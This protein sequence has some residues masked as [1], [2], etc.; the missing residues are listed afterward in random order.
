MVLLYS[1]RN[2]NKV[3]INKQYNIKAEMVMIDTTSQDFLHND[4]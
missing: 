1:Y 4:K 2:G 3:N